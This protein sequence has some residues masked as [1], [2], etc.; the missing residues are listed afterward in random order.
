MWHIDNGSYD[1]T[2]PPNPTHYAA[3]DFDAANP[4]ITLV[5]NNI[6]GNKNRFTYTDGTQTYAQTI[7][8]DHYTG[9][10]WGTSYQASAIYATNLANIHALT[11][12]GISLWRVPTVQENLTIS[13]ESLSGGA[14]NYAPFS[15]TD[16]VEHWS[17]ETLAASA[18]RGYTFYFYINVDFLTLNINRE[19]T[20]TY[21]TSLMVTNFS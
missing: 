11:H 17:N 18:S 21:L 7:T 6:H 9:L 10:I 12:A 16:T 2:P 1:Y 15:K 20:T 19:L 8:E 3:L 5:D 14:L 13:N 4:F